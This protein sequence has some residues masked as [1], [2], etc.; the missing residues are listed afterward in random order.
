[1]TDYNEKY[2][3]GVW[4]R[5]AYSLL[6]LTAT[7]VLAFLFGY[8]TKR[9]DWMPQVTTHLE[10]AVKVYHD[11][12]EDDWFKS[13]AWRRERTSAKGV[14][15]HDD[16]RAYQGATLYVSAHEQAAVLIDMEGK[17]LYRW[18]RSFREIW[19]TAPHVAIPRNPELI[20]YNNARVFPNG[21]LIVQFRGDGG[22]PWG[23]GL[24]K[25]DKDSNVVWALAENAH[26][27]FDVDADGN[28]YAVTHVNRDSPYVPYK[29][30]K[31]G[32]M[33]APY[34]INLPVLEDF[35]VILGPDGTVTRRISLLDAFVDSPYEAA[36]TYF[37]ATTDVLHVNDVDLV[38]DDMPE[39][40]IFKPGQALL[41]MRD[42]GILAVLDLETEKIVWAGRGVWR[43]QHDPDILA[44]GN[45]LIVDNRGALGKGGQTRVI[46]VNLQTGELVWSYEGDEAQPLD[47]RYQSTVQRLPNGNTL[48][49]EWEGGR[50]LEVTREGD[51]VWEYVVPVR[52]S[53]KGNQFHPVINAGQRIELEQLDFLT[54]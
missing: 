40:P 37:G 5:I 3:T 24:V 1:M 27:F 32:G 12:F 47:S 11:L 4:S 17:E 46:E 14:L 19:P 9:L 38:P 34:R 42:P 18:Q 49:T 31:F 21:D 23:Y 25:L 50:M 36:L 10:S 43:G 6:V 26:H 53:H 15:Q 8:L 52:R 44:N 20:V 22:H 30:L 28:V 7:A 33:R 45:V 35:L 29:E 39:H 51:I 16:T 48:I 41:D 54:E 2:Q 13:N